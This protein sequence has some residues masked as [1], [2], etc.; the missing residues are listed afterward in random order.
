MTEISSASCLASWLGGQA[1]GIRLRASGEN[2]TAGG[3]DTEKHIATDD[4]PRRARIVLPCFRAP[5][6][7]SFAGARPGRIADIRQAARSAARE[8]R[9]AMSETYHEGQMNVVESIS[10]QCLSRAEAYQRIGCALGSDINPLD[11]MEYYCKLQYICSSIPE[12]SH[13]HR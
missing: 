3:T 10:F 9:D 2:R 6:A 8:A 12:G 4:V 7:A 13:G 5:A 11:Y 1:T